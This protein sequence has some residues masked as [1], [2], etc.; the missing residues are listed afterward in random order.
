MISS[1]L[2]YLHMFHVAN[3]TCR[4]SFLHCKVILEGL[5]KGSKAASRNV[6][7][8]S[9]EIEGDRTGNVKS[10][11]YCFSFVFVFS[12]FCYAEMNPVPS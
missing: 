7:L 9:T 1:V 4:F 8:E 12:T 2:D 6:N 10:V 5:A 11:H 3:I